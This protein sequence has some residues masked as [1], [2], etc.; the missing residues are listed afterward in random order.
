MK[1]SQRLGS[2][3]CS[4]VLDVG[5][6]VSLQQPARCPPSR[7]LLGCRAASRER[8]TGRP[9]NHDIQEIHSSVFSVFQLAAAAVLM[10]PFRSSPCVR[11]KYTTA[12]CCT[13]EELGSC[14]RPGRGV[15]NGLK[16]GSPQLQGQPGSGDE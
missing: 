12:A 2:H 5:G 9:R 14:R 4:P 8:V 6:Q 1:S 3:L 10:P 11:T 13:A 16:T 15:K 7:V